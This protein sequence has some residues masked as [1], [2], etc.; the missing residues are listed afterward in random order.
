MAKENN[1]LSCLWC[2]DIYSAILLNVLIAMLGG[3]LF[4]LSDAAIGDLLS[5]SLA[6]G[7][8]S[9]VLLYGLASAIIL[10]KIASERYYPK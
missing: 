3:V 2:K 1:K 4:F 10:K 6:K 7:L 9:V 8:S 5:Y